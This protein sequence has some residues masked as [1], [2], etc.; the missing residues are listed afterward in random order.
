M[1]I[2]TF[3]GTLVASRLETTYT[4]TYLVAATSLPKAEEVLAR[5][6]Q[7]FYGKSSPSRSVE[8]GWLNAKGTEVMAPGP[9][10]AISLETFQE[11]AQFLPVRAEPDV[12]PPLAP[13]K[14][15]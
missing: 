2:K 4:L 13:K 3:V 6:A 12:L 1:K 7:T 15:A 9:V 8:K 14:L 5:L 11:M 10:H